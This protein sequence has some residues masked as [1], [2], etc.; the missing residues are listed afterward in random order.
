[1]EAFVDVK[2]ASDIAKFE[3]RQTFTLETSIAF[4][5]KKPFCVAAS[6]HN[7]TGWL[8]GR[9]SNLAFVDI[10]ARIIGISRACASARARTHFTANY[11]LA[12]ASGMAQISV[13]CIFIFFW[14]LVLVA[15]LRQQTFSNPA[16]SN[17]VR[18]TQM[19]FQDD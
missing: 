18:P 3:A 17:H 2:T 14:S 19:H 15:F 8:T 5:L 13:G 12:C 4:A 11:I 16:N 9:V 10:Y 7:M 1:M 6:R